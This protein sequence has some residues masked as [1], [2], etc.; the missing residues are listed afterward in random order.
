MLEEQ[1]YETSSG[2]PQSVALAIS[3]QGTDSVFHCCHNVSQQDIQHAGE[4]LSRYF[5]EQVPKEGADIASDRDTAK[6]YTL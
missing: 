3:S 5:L 2:V 1:V 6:D 4:K